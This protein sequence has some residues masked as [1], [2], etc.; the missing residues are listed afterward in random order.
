[1]IDWK[2]VSEAISFYEDQGYKYIEVPWLVDVQA[3][4]ATCPSDKTPIQAYHHG[5]NLG[6]L[7]GSAE[8]SF[9][10]MMLD[11]Q[12]PPGQYCAATPCFRDDQLDQYHQRHFFKVELIQIKPTSPDISDIIYTA[13]QF[14]ERYSPSELQVINTKDG[15]D[16]YCNGIEV[17]S[18]GYRQ[19]LQHE[20]IYGTGIALPRF[21]QAICI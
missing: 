4:Y 10:Q 7:V 20:W 5:L 12:L 8:Q 6:Y 3:V 11:S 2:F 15:Q 21:S 16:L 17:G 1:M 18:Y 19:Y 13:R 14:M 9:I